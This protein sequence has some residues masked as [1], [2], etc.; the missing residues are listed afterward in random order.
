MRTVVLDLTMNLVNRT[1]VHDMGMEIYNLDPGRFL[2]RYGRYFRTKPINFT[3]NPVFSALG[4]AAGRLVFRDLDFKITKL[5]SRG[6][7][8]RIVFLGTLILA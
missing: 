1:A 4:K 3:K 5:W 7:C 6:R 8:D 2:V